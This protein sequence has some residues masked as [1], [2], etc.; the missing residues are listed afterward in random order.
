MEKARYLYRVE[1]PEH[2]EVQVEAIDRLRAISGAARIW[3]VPGHRL[4]GSAPASGSGKASEAKG[5]PR[6]PAKKRERGGAAGH[7]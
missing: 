6:Q 7:E 3:G 2:G 1:H 5:K 4:P